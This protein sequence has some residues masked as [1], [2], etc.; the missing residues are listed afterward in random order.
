MQVEGQEDRDQDH[1]EDQH[2]VAHGHVGQRDRGDDADQGAD[3]P[4]AALEEGL[5][6]GPGAG[7]GDERRDH[8][9][10]VAGGREREAEGDGEQ[11]GD[12]HLGGLAGGHRDLG[13][14]VEPAASRRH[15][16]G[17]RGRAGEPAQDQAGRG[18]ELLLAGVHL[19]R[20]VG[21]GVEAQE[22]LRRRRPRA[23]PATSRRRPAA[24]LVGCSDQRVAPRPPAARSRRRARW[25][26]TRVA[27][28][29]TAAFVPRAGQVR[30]PRR[31]TA[32]RPAGS[33][34]GG[35]AARSATS[36]SGAAPGSEDQASASSDASAIAA[37]RP[38]TARW[39][40]GSDAPGA[41]AVGSCEQ[42]GALAGHRAAGGEEGR[43]GRVRA[44]CAGG[45]AAR[46]VVSSS[47]QTR[48]DHRGDQQL[49]HE[50]QRGVQ[51]GGEEEAHP[52]HEPVGEP[53]A[54]RSGAPTRP[55]TASPRTR[56][57]GTAGDRR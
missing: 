37:W 51:E 7:E 9:P 5:R 36:P 45:C 42:V 30:W 56:P 50:G 38:A 35:A 52:G 11:P 12:R 13:E 40:A 1:R 6:A 43:D 23:A 28:A 34:S 20:L 18:L 39:R 55:G 32:R 15:V 2:G 3:D 49:G 57:P 24:V 31:R 29:R 41:V 47:T 53:A 48:R 14:R 54:D 16:A 4:R 44:R 17:H 21:G 33:R 19:R 27:S 26:S 46:V 25:S 10:V 22:L 8:R